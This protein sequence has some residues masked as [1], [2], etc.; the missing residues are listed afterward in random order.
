VNTNRFCYAIE[1]EYYIDVEPNI[2]SS[3]RI[4]GRLRLIGAHKRGKV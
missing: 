4:Q 1:V 2:S 3:E